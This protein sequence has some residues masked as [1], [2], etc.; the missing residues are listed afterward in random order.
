MKLTR[1]GKQKKEAEKK[2]DE[3]DDSKDE[4]LPVTLSQI[5]SVGGR[6]KFVWNR[7]E[8]TV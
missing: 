6:Q 3:Q 1:R 8:M 4:A 2:V 7:S 5:I